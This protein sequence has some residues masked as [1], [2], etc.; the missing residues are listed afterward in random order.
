MIVLSKEQSNIPL[1]RVLATLY[2]NK[3]KSNKSYRF[4]NLISYKMNAWFFFG[5]RNVPLDKKPSWCR[6]V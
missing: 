4:L 2:Y 3:N 6:F 5:K 1:K